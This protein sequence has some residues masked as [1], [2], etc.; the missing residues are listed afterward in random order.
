M[1]R[2]SKG[3]SLRNKIKIYC[4]SLETEY[5]YF[6][7]MKEKI[8]KSGIKDISIEIIKTQKKGGKDPVTAVNY[9]IKTRKDANDV[10]VV[11]DKDENDIEKAI[12]LAGRNDVKIAWSNECFE[13]WIL[14]HFEKHNKYLDRNEC[15]KSVNKEYKKEFKREYEKNTENIYNSLENRQEFAVAVSK[16]QHE[17]AIK[18]KKTPNRANPCTLVYKLVEMLRR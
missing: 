10:W 12:E 4:N 18:E 8:N 2:K 6:N 1:G 16:K 14:N 11:F 9:A 15:I 3:L 17:M 5:N 13:L 7:G